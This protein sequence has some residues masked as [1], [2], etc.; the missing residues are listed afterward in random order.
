MKKLRLFVPTD[1]GSD[2][3]SRLE[4]DLDFFLPGDRISIQ[5]RSTRVSATLELSRLSM[6]PFPSIER[7][8]I[9][10]WNDAM[11]AWSWHS[12]VSCV[13]RAEF[14]TSFHNTVAVADALSRLR[15]LDRGEASVFGTGPSL[16]LAVDRDHSRSVRIVANTIVADRVSLI[17]LDPH[18]LVAGDALYHFSSEQFAQRFRNDALRAM[19]LLPD[20]LFIY[21]AEF[22]S[23]VSREFRSVGARLV[24]VR[25]CR[26]AAS[27]LSLATGEN[28]LP[29][30]GNV[31]QL[32]LLP[33]ATAVAKSVHLF[34]FDGRRPSD[35]AFWSNSIRHDYP[36]ERALL[37]ENNP[38]F[39]RFF[40][41]QEDPEK[42]VTSVLGDGLEMQLSS[43]ERRGWR[44]YVHGKS[45]TPALSRRVVPDSSG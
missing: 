25:R 43:A 14:Q 38:A 45:T 32:L 18:V 28:C 33:L 15:T 10:P 8:A 9:D 16:A 4:R 44:F 3:I 30:L 1:Y 2:R 40:V 31:L 7:W 37:H 36:A 34:G 23:I 29:N 22:H 5:R 11:A 12:V 39:L 21:P 19:M 35:V 17:R 42:Y 26:K 27:V 6:L 13:R 20:L 24:P 41:P